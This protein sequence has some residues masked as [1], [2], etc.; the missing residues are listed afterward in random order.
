M[1]GGDDRDERERVYA[2]IAGT[3][4]Q[5]ASE[6]PAGTF[7]VE[8]LREYVTALVPG[9]APDS[10]GRILRLLREEG[11]LNYVVISRAASLYQFRSVE[12][13]PALAQQ[14]APKPTP[15][16]PLTLDLFDD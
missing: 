8:E 14:P 3:I 2:R 12:P 1:S 4:L 11:K 9:I 10:P 16:G 7:H 6:H 5:F 13:K 15:P